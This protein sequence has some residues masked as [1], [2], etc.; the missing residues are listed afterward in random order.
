MKKKGFTLIELLAVIVILAI[1]AIIAVP[2]IT[3][4]VD[5][6]KKGAVKS[7]VL[8]YIDAVE[9]QTMI[10]QIDSSKTKIEDGTYQL[11]SKQYKINSSVG[12]LN[13][14]DTVKAEEISSTIYLNNIVNVKGKK[15]TSGYLVIEKGKVINGKMIMDGYDATYDISLPDKVVI[16][17]KVDSNTIDVLID[18]VQISKNNIEVIFSVDGSSMK[19]ATCKYGTNMNYGHT[20]TIDGNKCIIPYET[21]SVATYYYQ[22]EVTTTNNKNGSAEGSEKVY[23]SNLSDDN[24]LKQE[25]LT[26]VANNKCKYIEL[27]H[28]EKEYT[29]KEET[30]STECAGNY[31]LEV[32]GAQGGGYNATG[33]YGAYSVGTVDLS[34]S[35]TLYINVGGQ[36]KYVSSSGAGYNGGGNAGISNSGSGGGATHIALVSGLLK[37]LNDYKGEY[38]STKKIYISNKILIVAGGGG[39]TGCDGNG[40][41]CVNGAAAGGYIGYTDTTLYGGCAGARAACYGTGGSQYSYGVKGSYAG[42]SGYDGAFGQGGNGRTVASAEGCGGGGGGGF[43]GGGGAAWGAAGGGSGYIA[44]SSLF[45]KHMTCYNCSTSDDA[46]IKTQTTTNVSDTP[47]ADYAK[48]GAG[49][50]RITYLGK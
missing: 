18:S 3:K 8:G 1:I 41:R 26:Q 12:L 44:N 11:S 38:D 33:G 9:K 29:G 4:V 42:Y 21:D 16:N 30:Y 13:L 36:G 39:G 34:K 7:S 48:T 43:F 32:W 47:I 6:A 35:T 5:K 17:K 19:S 45:N 20:G 28:Y 31:K 2:A 15:P 23:N 50:V 10:N 49:Y 40:V 14:I 27:V 24:P 37:D 25:Y 22:I 46:E